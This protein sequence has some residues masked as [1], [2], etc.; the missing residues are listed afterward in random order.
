MN[1]EQFDD[2]L[3]GIVS[4]GHIPYNEKSW[5]ALEQ[6][7]NRGNKKRLLLLLPFT[8]KQQAAA[9]CIAII[10][11]LGTWMFLQRHT[12]I[13]QVAAVK[14]LKNEITGK[15]IS[16]AKN[17]TVLQYT[18]KP[19][20]NAAHFN[21]LAHH[22]LLTK[23]GLA[24]PVPPP[25]AASA[26]NA[27]HTDN[28]KSG[29]AAIEPF[30]S[31][32]MK[33]QQPL[34]FNEH[35]LQPTRKL[36]MILNGGIAVASGNNF[37]AG[38]TVSKKISSRFSLE[39]SIGYAQGNHDV[40]TKYQSD[41][42]N[43]NV[44]HND[45]GVQS[46]SNTE[47]ETWYEQHKRNLPYLQFSPA[48]SIKLHRKL[49]ASIGADLQKILIDASMLSQINDNMPAG[50]KKIPALDPG[51]LMGL[52]YSLT[53]RIS[54]GVAYRQ[55]MINISGDNYSMRNYFLVQLKYAVIK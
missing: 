22:S 5:D 40:F 53:K 3:R 54:S 42:T 9:A 15:K 17:A 52:N 18:V 16:P 25:Y 2:T 7:L 27:T 45:T 38:I 31:R 14:P 51:L 6:R 11:S 44:H 35:D 10:A 32:K 46:V 26:D 21:T 12:T 19:L 37:S 33:P 24:K 28:R 36:S 34:L 48:V 20:Q 41:V 55:S 49:S 29:L 39:T 47:A 13:T 30:T 23:A 50:N 43:T 4:G 8:L 1:T